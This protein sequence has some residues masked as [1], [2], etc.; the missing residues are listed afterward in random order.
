MLALDLD[1]SGRC[2]FRPLAILLAATSDLPPEHDTVDRARWIRRIVP[3]VERTP[4]SPPCPTLA[5]TAGCG[6][7][8]SLVNQGHRK[9]WWRRGFTTAAGQQNMDAPMRW[10]MVGRRGHECSFLQ[11]QGAWDRQRKNQQGSARPVGPSPR[12]VSAPM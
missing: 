2:D 8:R 10:R 5:L 6:G 12:C 9:S 3:C 1:L 7:D 4:R 11:T